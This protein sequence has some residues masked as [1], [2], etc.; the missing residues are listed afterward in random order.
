MIDHGRPNFE[1]VRAVFFDLDDT[2][3]AYWDASKI[4]MRRAFERF[5]P[6]GITVDEMIR[7]WAAA[8]REFSPTLKQT[9]WYDGYLK[10]GEPTRTEQMRLTL[11]RVG[12]TDPSRTAALSQAYFEERDRAL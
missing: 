1:S 4:G 11:L 12:V 2:L 8:F 9:G 10:S 3:C 6:P 7:H 5:G